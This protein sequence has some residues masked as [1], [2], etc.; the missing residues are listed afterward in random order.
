MLTG[1]STLLRSHCHSA[2]C[3]VYAGTPIQNNIIELHTLL[4]FLNPKE[5]SA[6]DFEKKYGQLNE[7]E[8]IKSLHKLLKPYLLRRMK[9]DV[10]KGLPAR[11]ETIIEVELSITQKKYYKAVF[12]KNTGYLLAN[13]REKV[14]LMNIAMQLRKCCNHPFLLQ[15]VEEQLLTPGMSKLE[16]MDTLINSSGKM[17]LLDKVSAPCSI[18]TC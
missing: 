12:E 3:D 17:V 1:P 8:Q 7:T 5:L 13:S 11:E 16:M 10:E 18:G 9:E 4:Q 6:K 14:S 15:G 2:P